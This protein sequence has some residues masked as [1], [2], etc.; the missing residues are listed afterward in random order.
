M[1]RVKRAPM[2]W[3]RVWVSMGSVSSY[4]YEQSAHLYINV[5]IC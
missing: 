5:V 3:L 1:G 2:H 4:D